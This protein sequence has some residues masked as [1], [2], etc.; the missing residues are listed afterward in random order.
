MN[1]ENINK[2]IAIME[3]A[4]ARDSVYMAAFQAPEDGVTFART[5]EELHTCGNRA[6][7]AGHIAVSPEWLSEPGHTSDDDGSPITDDIGDNSK[8][9]ADWWGLS[10]AGALRSIADYL[11]YGYRSS[12]SKQN[13]YGISWHDVKAE[14]VI[15]QLTL[16]RDLGEDKY[17][18]L[19]RMD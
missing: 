2:T 7:L 9:V 19:K 18:Q 11:I 5:E 4:K 15:E 14:H 17:R 13:V 8:A 6:C 16:L 1:I 3:R 12:I 10:D